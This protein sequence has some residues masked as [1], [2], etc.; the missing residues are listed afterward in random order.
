MAHVFI[1]AMEKAQME[2]YLGFGT[3]L[4]A[5]RDGQIIPWTGEYNNSSLELFIVL[6]ITNFFNDRKILEYL[7]SNSFIR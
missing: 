6:F 1:E 3:L 7:F 4:G 2:Y 5:V